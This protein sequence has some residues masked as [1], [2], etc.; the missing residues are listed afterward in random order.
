LVSTG[1][2]LGWT[3]D[4]QD[5]P[6]FRPTEAEFRD[7]FAYL[8]KIR[9]EAASYGICKIIPPVRPAVSAGLVLKE[10]DFK[11]TTNVQYLGVHKPDR[12][13]AKSSKKNVFYR[14]GKVYNLN[15]FQKMANQEMSKKFGCAGNLPRKVVE[16]EYWRE[17]LKE[18]S[19]RV[20]Y[21]SDLDASGFAPSTDCPMARSKWNL[22]EFAKASSSSLSHIGERIPGVTDPML[23]CGMMFSQFA[24][25]VEDCF[26]NSINYHHQGSP[27]LWYGVPSSDALKFD[28]VTYKHVFNKEGAKKGGLDLTGATGKDPKD[29]Q[30]RE[31]EAAMHFIKK[32]TMFPPSILLENGVKVCR[33]LQQPGEFVVT[34]PQAYHG[35]FSTG[36]NVGEAVNFAS[37]DWFNFGVSAEKRYQRLRLAPVVSLEELTSAE[38][39]RRR[40][41]AKREAA[42]PAEGSAAAAAAAAAVPDPLVAV[43]RHKVQELLEAVN[44]LKPAI[45]VGTYQ[46]AMSP[47]NC[48]VCSKL[49]YLSVFVGRK[50][51]PGCLDCAMGAARA[52]GARGK[53]QGTLYI[54][55][56]LKENT[57]F[58][59]A[60]RPSSG[61]AE[62]DSFSKILSLIDSHL[63]TRDVTDIDV[64]KKA[65]SRRPSHCLPRPRQ[66]FSSAPPQHVDP[67]QGPLAQVCPQTPPAE[68]SSDSLTCDLV[69]PL[70]EHMVA[71]PLEPQT[72]DEVLGSSITITNPL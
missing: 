54:N 21:G 65:R 16:K 53:L 47:T 55:P 3:E 34:F 70:V 12:K 37:T 71:E 44:F 61:G 6:V 14:S 64:P 68:A 7:P 39:D 9:A 31:D 41:A 5:G 27:K 40:A 13:I 43:W 23:Y 57:E 20:E 69:D 8:E 35:G 50:F 36:F 48:E 33:I 66:A 4:I 28:Q 62:S 60:V 29:L 30:R 2:T 45:V 26:L 56:K 1:P 51:G 17:V 19:R 63:I 18:D 25:H 59:N 11:F 72:L 24:W 52:K 15:T 49:C 42:A 58:L 22:K 38:L 67:L 46:G 32:T 10:K